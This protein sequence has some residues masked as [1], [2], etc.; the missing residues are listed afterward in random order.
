MLKKNLSTQT[1]FIS[2][3]LLLTLGLIFLAGLHYIVN[4]QYQEPSGTYSNSGPV[5]SLVSS[6]SLDLHQPQDSTLSFSPSILFSGK[7]SPNTLVLISSQVIDQMLE[8]K[9]DGTFSLVFDLEVGVNIISLAAFDASG[10]Q[11]TITK[12]IYYSKEKI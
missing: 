1:F 8:S 12:T 7:T 11:K 2:Q 10:N 3:L 6:L 4:I 9:T 5:T